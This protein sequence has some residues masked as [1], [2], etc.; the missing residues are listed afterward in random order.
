MSV[1][2]IEDRE[3]GVRLLVLQRAKANAFDLELMLALSE[4]FQ[5]GIRSSA[6]RSFVV[7]GS[8]KFFS[9]GLDL[10]ALFQAQAQGGEAQK[11][12]T[13]AMHH[14]FMDVWT[15]PK[16]TVA[17][18][19][20]HAIAAGYLV[21]AACDFR[22]V[23]ENQSQFGLNELVFGAG[24]PPIAIEI[25]RYI[26]G[27]RFPQAIL[28]A[29]LFNWKT[30]LENGSFHQSFFSEGLLVQA[31][32]EYAAK[33]GKRPQE[34]YAHVKAQLLAPHLQRV[35]EEP[36]AHRQKTAAIYAS[37]ES[38]TAISAYIKSIVGG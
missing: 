26:M 24:F 22:Y 31:A 7:T 11:Q 6:V 21:A 33:L 19:N 37:P 34:A 18:V 32:C 17:A 10:Q 29:Q 1:I 27:S 36:D 35:L 30:G 9:A 15:C 4:A 2:K 14:A 16:P 13:E 28:S 12:F 3:N 20:G 38:M 25:G 23:C 8:G 5:E